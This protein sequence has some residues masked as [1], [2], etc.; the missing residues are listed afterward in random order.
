MQSLAALCHSKLLWN[1]LRT[2]PH[3]TLEEYIELTSSLFHSRGLGY[4]ASSFDDEVL[5]GARKAYWIMSETRHHVM[6]VTSRCLCGQCH[7]SWT[8]WEDLCRRW[9]S[10]HVEAG[11]TPHMFGTSDRDFVNDMKNFA[12]FEDNCPYSRLSGGWQGAPFG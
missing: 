3:I 5:K 9:R 8:P 12:T 10:D 11:G 1:A 2:D 4:V 6:S 7:L